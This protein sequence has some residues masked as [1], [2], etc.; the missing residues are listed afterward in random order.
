[1]AKMFHAMFQRVSLQEKGLHCPTPLKWTAKAQFN[2]HRYLD[3]T[4]RLS[5]T[6]MY[7]FF[8]MQINI[9]KFVKYISIFFNGLAYER[10]RY[11]FCAEKAA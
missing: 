1:M 2:L 9:C 11:V 10:S 5:C 7:S 3:F 4:V 8:V 6:E